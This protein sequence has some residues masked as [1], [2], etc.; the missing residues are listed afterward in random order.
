MLTVETSL[1]LL[2]LLEETFFYLSTTKAMPFWPTSHAEWL[3]T[4]SH[5]KGRFLSCPSPL[6]VVILL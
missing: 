5:S 1:A 6:L 2:S 4:I 3:S